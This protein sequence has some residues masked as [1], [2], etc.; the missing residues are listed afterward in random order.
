[1]SGKTQTPTNGQTKKPEVQTTVAAAEIKKP[2]VAKLESADQ[3]HL[4]A[5]NLAAAEQPKP[6]PKIL[7]MQERL[8]RFY[9][10]QRLEEKREQIIEALER[11]NGFQLSGTGGENMRLQ[12]SKGQTFSISHP[13]IIGEMVHQ[14]K[15]KLQQ[16]LAEVEAQFVI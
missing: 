15:S 5:A 16:L 3:V 2:D 7:T 13:I 9:E 6:Q 14:A 10:L 1:M 4:V 8:D 11:V 12:D